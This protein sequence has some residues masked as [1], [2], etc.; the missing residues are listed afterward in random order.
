[1]ASTKFGKKVANT[2]FQI[3]GDD[4]MD[5]ESV[6]PIKRKI[7][8]I[9]PYTMPEISNSIKSREVKRLKTKAKPCLK[10]KP[11]GRPRKY[12]DSKVKMYES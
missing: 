1:M 9:L 7:S 8:K 11:I 10:P 6:G 12:V 4:Q 3:K 2:L 5:T